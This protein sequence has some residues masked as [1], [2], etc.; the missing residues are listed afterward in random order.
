MD[1]DTFLDGGFARLVE[2][3]GKKPNG[4]KA[5]KEAMQLP[6]SKGQGKRLNATLKLST[7]KS[8]HAAVRAPPAAGS[9]EQPDAVGAE[10]KSH[11]AQLEELKTADPEFYQYLAE[12]DKALL[13]FS[14][15]EDGDEVLDD[16]D[17]GAPESG[18]DD[19][20][21]VDDG[22]NASGMDSSF[23]GVLPHKWSRACCKVLGEGVL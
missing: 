2:E 4:S 20:V 14:E 12:S 3:G 1:I 15:D 13:E 8:E 9:H 7:P 23:S 11:K 17:V 5:E 6:Q 16:D 21:P 10:I 19:A 18:A 22:R